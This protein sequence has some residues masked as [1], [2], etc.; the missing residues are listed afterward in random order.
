[1]D[2]HIQNIYEEKESIKQDIPLQNQQTILLSTRILQQQQLQE[3]QKEKQK[4]QL[5]KQTD[6]NNKK[7]M[8]YDKILSSLNMQV[9]DGRLQIARKIDES[10]QKNSVKNE[11][12]VSFQ[13]QNYTQNALVQ[14]HTPQQLRQQQLLLQQQR[15]QSYRANLQQQGQ[16]Q[17][18]GQFQQRQPQQTQQEINIEED[19]NEEEIPVFEENPNIVSITRQQLIKRALAIQHLKNFQEKKKIEKLK[20]RRMSFW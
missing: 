17:Q 19:Y 6:E 18:T 8:S 14:K 16:P 12:K 10:S 4:E 5:Q 11:K 1:M 20:P 15:I 2:F 13:N 7:I 9:V 3:Q